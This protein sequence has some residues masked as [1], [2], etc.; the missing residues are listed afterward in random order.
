M[1]V[2]VA[3]EHACASV[4][5]CAA[6]S[7]VCVCVCVCVENAP[8]FM[9]VCMCV[10]ACMSQEGADDDRGTTDKDE[11][12]TRDYSAPTGEDK[13]NKEML[14][15]VMQVSLSCTCLGTSIDTS[16][17]HVLHTHTHTHTYCANPS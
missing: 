6:S 9:F 11:I 17:A 10:C 15:K 13:F 3:E 16:A 7:H 8:P 5:V 1:C 2:C 14:P 4:F 12:F